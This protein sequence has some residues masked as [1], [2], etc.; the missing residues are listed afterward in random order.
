MDLSNQVSLI[1]LP[2]SHEM[3]SLD[4]MRS[5]DSIYKQWSKIS[6]LSSGHNSLIQVINQMTRDIK[7][8]SDRLTIGLGFFP[9]KI[10]T[11]PNFFRPTTDQLQ[12]TASANWRTVRVRGGYVFADYISTQ[13]YVQGTDGMELYTDLSTLP[14]S[15]VGYYDIQ[16][17]ESQSM[18]WFF[19][20]QSG[21]K[22]SVSSSYYLRYAATTPASYSAIGNPHPWVSFPS[23]SFGTSSYQYYP[24][25]WCDSNTSGSTNNLLIRQIQ[26]TDIVTSALPPTFTASF[27]KATGGY[28]TYTIYGNPIS[29]S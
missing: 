18:F 17:P 26:R 13:S 12:Y 1:S 15:S 23:A 19:I 6:E 24:I 20:E 16:V 11:V 3:S 27:C 7:R 22:T 21:S 10:Y 29:G 4:S 2:K 14:S 28:T 9:F 5:S 25:G 8:L